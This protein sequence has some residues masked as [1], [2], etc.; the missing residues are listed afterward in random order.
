ME[1]KGGDIIQRRTANTP[2]LTRSSFSDL[3]A[4]NQGRIQQSF[5]KVEYFTSSRR[6]REQE[7]LEGL[8]LALHCL[9]Y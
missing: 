4:P 2:C 9:I 5:R 7:H 1:H 8:E 6:P 3:Y